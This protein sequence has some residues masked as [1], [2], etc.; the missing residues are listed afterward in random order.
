MEPNPEAR[1]NNKQLSARMGVTIRTLKRRSKA[2]GVPPTVPLV[3]HE[4]WSQADAARLE[5]RWLKHV[6]Q[7]YA[8]KTGHPITGPQANGR[9]SAGPGPCHT[10]TEPS[11][12]TLTGPG[13]PSSVKP[14]ANTPAGRS[15]RAYGQENGARGSLGT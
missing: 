10:L 4:E 12:G 13:S 11:A 15:P 2:V 1:L 6:K 3:S 8:E 9:R 5:R 14:L 7:R